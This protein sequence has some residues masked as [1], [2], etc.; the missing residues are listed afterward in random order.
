MKNLAKWPWLV[1]FALFVP[2]LLCLWWGPIIV[3]LHLLS[4]LGVFGKVGVTGG[5]IISVTIL[6][7]W[8]SFI[9]KSFIHTRVEPFFNIK[10]AQNPHDDLFVSEPIVSFR[11]WLRFMFLG[12]K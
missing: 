2:V 3:L 8:S 1:R 10:S 12:R 5:F 6:W 9:M 4:R 7:A 11:D